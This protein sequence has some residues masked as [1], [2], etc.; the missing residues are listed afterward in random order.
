MNIL[1]NSAFLSEYV[2]LDERGEKVG[3]KLVT[4]GK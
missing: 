4:S 2:S 3:E 1:A